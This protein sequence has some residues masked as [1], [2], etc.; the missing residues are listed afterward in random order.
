MK[1]IKGNGDRANFYRTPVAIRLN[2]V[3]IALERTFAWDI[4]PT[5]ALMALMTASDIVSDTCL[6][7]LANA[8]EMLADASAMLLTIGP[9]RA[10]VISTKFALRP[11]GSNFET[12]LQQNGRFVS[13][14]KISATKKLLTSAV[15]VHSSGE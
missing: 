13:T 1:T 11:S 4:L 2:P 8:S 10:V 5:A 12:I 7:L 15:N 6:I 9:L 3:V 14:R